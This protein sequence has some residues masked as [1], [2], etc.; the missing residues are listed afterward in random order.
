VTLSASPP[1]PPM[2]RGRLLPEARHVVL[3]DG[4]VASGWPAVRETCARIGWGFD[5]WQQDLNTAIL[6]KAAD[7]LLAADT[8]AMSICRQAGKTYDI[9]GLVFADSIINPGTT[10]V[11]TAH[12]FKVA[13][14]SFDSL[15]AMA[16]S[17]LLAPHID[18]DAITTAAGNET[19]PFRN[20]SRLVFAARERGTIRG[21]SK[22]RRLILDEGQILTESAMSDLAPTM[23]QAHDP[24]I[25][26]M[27]TPPKPSDPSEFFSNLRASALDG[28]AEGLLYVELGA[29]PG[30]DLDD[31]GAWA[32]ANPSYPHRTPERSI[33]RLRKLLSDDDFA[34]EALGIWDTQAM[35]GVIDVDRWR[36]LKDPPDRTGRGGSQVRD[37][38]PV[39]FSADVAPDRKH[40]SVAVVGERADGRA[41]LEVMPGE[42]GTAWI[43]PWLAERARKWRGSVV[44]DPGAAAGSLVPELQKAGVEPILMTT[45]D[46]GQACGMFFDAVHEDR[47]RHLDDPRLNTALA[48]GRKRDIGVNGLWAWHRRDTSTDLT[49]LVATTQ[50]LWG[51]LSRQG[52]SKS[53]RATGRSRSY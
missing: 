11:W 27:G 33:L 39:V 30:S 15:R 29:E 53:K 48:A 26:I 10:S 51:L 47:L 20:G 21:F 35:L 25:I 5:P 52:E 4:I 40:G 37:G 31:R 43:A 44:I 24:Q 16:R 22:V 19:I 38:S 36:G 45:R 46:V 50:A 32:R 3:P 1:R 18:Y 13:R 2:S 7:G 23:N 34:R 42:P 49:P 9:G 17:P 6:A 12:R 14:E 41:H 8:V 28:G